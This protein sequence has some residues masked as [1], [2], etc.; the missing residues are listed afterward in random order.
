MAAIKGIDKLN[1]AI[2]SKVGEAFSI[3][4]L[5]QMVFESLGERASDYDLKIVRGAVAV[6]EAPLSFVYILTWQ[7]SDAELEAVFE[8]AILRHEW[9]VYGGE[10]RNARMTS[11]DPLWRYVR[12]PDLIGRFGSEEGAMGTYEAVSPKLEW[13][14]NTRDRKNGYLVEIDQYSYSPDGSEYSCGLV[15]SKVHFKKDG[16]RGDKTAS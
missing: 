16:R 7:G 8:S 15:D 13:I 1:S 5:E 3:E 12:E 10:V 2:T 14:L 9:R 11:A 6:Q 4:C